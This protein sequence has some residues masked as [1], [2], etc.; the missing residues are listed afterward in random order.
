MRCPTSPAT[1][2]RRTSVTAIALQVSFYYGLAGL[3]CAW[4]YR[5]TWRTPGRFVF[6][7]I[8][9]LVSAL[10][11]GAVGVYAFSTFDTVTRIVG[12]GGLLL[13]ILFFRPKGY[14]TKEAPLLDANEGEAAYPAAV[15]LN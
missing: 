5:D 13:G 2:T 1:H 14:R 15:D 3:S 8:Y 11:L 12:L 10:F 4:L 9:P 7:A 6:Y